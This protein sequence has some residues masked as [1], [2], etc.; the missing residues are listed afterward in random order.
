MARLLAGAGTALFGLAFVL[1]ALLVKL[2]TWLHVVSIDAGNARG[3]QVLLVAGVVLA[4]S[5]IVVTIRQS[6]TY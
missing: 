3:V 5:G 2:L 6:H 4:L 1:S